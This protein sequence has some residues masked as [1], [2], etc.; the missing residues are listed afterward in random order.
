MPSNNYNKLIDVYR[1]LKIYME[2]NGQT[3]FN[4]E[5]LSEANDDMRE[6]ALRAVIIKLVDKGYAERVER[7]IYKLIYTRTSYEAQL[8]GALAN[9]KRLLKRLN[10][11]QNLISTNDDQIET[12]KNQIHVEMQEDAGSCIRTLD[13][14]IHDRFKY[15][16]NQAIQR[17]ENE[18]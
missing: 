5:T 14:I 17:I 10:D 3:L 6:N 7:G 13:V 4:F 2:V 9:R 1:R 11:I 8:K 18:A 16:A 12:I 15:F